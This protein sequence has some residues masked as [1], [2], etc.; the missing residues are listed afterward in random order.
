MI[1]FPIRYR[2]TFVEL[3]DIL[4]V[5]IAWYGAF[6]LR[7]NLEV[8]TAFNFAFSEL[9][10]LVLILM[11]AQWAVSRLVGLH[12]GMWAF[13]SILDLQRV[14]SATVLSWVILLLAVTL[15]PGDVK[16]PRSVIV[17]Y[18]L[19]LAIL[20]SGGRLGWRML[21]DRSVFPT[22]ARGT[23]VLIV[24]AGTAGMMLVRELKRTHEWQVVALVDDAPHKQ[25]LQLLG[26]SVEGGIKDIPRLLRRYGAE[27]VIFA[28]PSA[29]SEVLRRVNEMAAQVNAQLYTV[30]GLHELMG[31]RVAINAMRPVR[32]EDLLGRDAVQIDNQNVRRIL[33]GRRLLVT[34][35]G[36]SIGS[37][38]C[39]QLSRFEPECIILVEVSEYAL[40]KINEWFKEYCPKVQVVPLTAD[41]R[42]V[43]RIRQIFDEYKPQVVF[44]AAAYKHVPLMEVGNAWQAVRN[45]V[46]GTYVLAREAVRHQCRRFVL[47]ST[48]KAVNPTNVM[49]A[50]K[51]M[52]EMVCQAMQDKG[53]VTK[54]Q[55][56]RFGNVLGS[57][58]SVIPRFREQIANGGPVTVTHP[59]VT[60]YFMS[61]P[62][63]AQLVLQAAAMGEGGEV[64]V[65][66]M[67]EPVKILQLA[68]NMIHLA[69][70]TEDE[71]EIV[72]TGLRPGE[73]MY[74]ELLADAEQTVKTP[75]PKLRIARARPAQTELIHE[76]ESWLQ[77]SLFYTDEEVRAL[78]K[79]WVEEYKP[80]AL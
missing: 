54:F 26:C 4:A 37:E 75:H 20:M 62:E 57:T 77:H 21:R 28:M 47:I 1:R 29:G 39:R 80:S 78:L 38:L 53:S 46:V 18:P 30:P 72:F 11:V 45:N 23:P 9:W 43:V 22:K 58:G 55:M 34:G 56:V 27:H 70:Y 17:L 33:A 76:V 8:E 73:K 42:D 7:F 5:P 69:G 19:L 13:A 2:T 12:R 63:A 3:F 59:E 60:R 6:W 66:D 49:G 71:I 67:G 31:G 74:E 41:V 24:G 79:Q 68:K 51:R 14:L 15:L 40:Y 65:L 25:G 50:T 52:A 32:V 16:V 64:F 36:G 48:D 10:L 35:A 44:H 61:I